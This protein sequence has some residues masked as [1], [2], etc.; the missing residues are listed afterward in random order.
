MEDVVIRNDDDYAR[1]G[2]L[3]RGR[4]RSSVFRDIVF[5]GDC[6]ALFNGEVGDLGAN[7]A[8][9]DS[10]AHWRGNQYSGI[11]HRG[12]CSYLLD[13]SD[14]GRDAWYKNYENRFI[15][16]CVPDDEIRFGPDDVVV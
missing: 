14:V 5:Q 11:F 8:Y 15:D 7:V 6:I 1:V 9:P 3:F 12:D 16:V 10:F 4:V 2:G 13:A